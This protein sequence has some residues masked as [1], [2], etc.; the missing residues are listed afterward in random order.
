MEA[1]LNGH[2]DVVQLLLD[3]SERVELNARDN[4][5]NTAFIFACYGAKK[6]VIQLLVDNSERIEVNETV[7]KRT[8]RVY[9]FSIKVR[10]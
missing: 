6:N 1:C 8:Q 2:K 10:K 7:L 5:G 3:H 9:K 4:I